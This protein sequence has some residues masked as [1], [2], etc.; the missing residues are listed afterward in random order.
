[1]SEREQQPGEQRRNP[2]PADPGAPDGGA[3]TGAVEEE[4]LER[5]QQPDLMQAMG[6][7]YGIAE[8]VAPGIVFVAVYTLGSNDISP[9]AWSAVAVAAV[10][11]GIRVFR[12]ETT[13]FAL[14]GLI[15][16][17]ISAFI[18]SRTGRAEDFFLPGLLLNAGYATAYAVSNL[19]RWPLIG[20]IMG[21]LTGGGMEWRADASQVRAYSRA[22]WIWVGMFLTR[23]AVQLPLY[24]A[25][26]VVALGVVRTAMGLPVFA[27]AIWLSYLVLR[28]A[29]MP[30]MNRPAR[31]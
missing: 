14:A 11:A 20:V 26:S 28:G 25:G 27:L 7:P 15:G 19:V 8:S 6:G 13:Q 17:G 2:I 31:S 21:P 1:M 29:G 30:W 9:A 23:L 18:A 5:G 4:A 3:H 16:V 12:R 10:L 24:L 22:T